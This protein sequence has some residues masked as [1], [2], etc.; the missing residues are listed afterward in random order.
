VRIYFNWKEY[1]L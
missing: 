1:F